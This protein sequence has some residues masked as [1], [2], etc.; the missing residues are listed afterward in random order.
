MR[1][2]QSS[3]TIDAQIRAVA[4]RQLGVITVEQAQ[5]CGV[6]RRALSRRR[7]SG[8]LVP[9]FREV[10]VLA[11][12]AVTQSQRAL[13][14]SLV[15]PGSVIA[16]TS[17]A[18]LHG[19]PVPGGASTTDDVVL[20]VDAQRVVRIPGVTVVRHG[21]MLPNRPWMTVRLATPAATLLLLPR[22]VDDTVVERCLD[23]SLANRLVSVA[24]IRRLLDQT[25]SRAVHKRRLLIGLLDARAYGVRHR[26]AG[27]QRIARW[28]ARAELTGWTPNL[29]VSVGGRQRVEVDFGWSDI[30][31]ALEVSPFF[32]HGSR[33]KQERDAQRRRLLVAAN[34]RVIEAVDGDI[35]D[36]HAFH[37]TITV[38]RSLGAT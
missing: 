9:V 27:E 35:A 14:A 34:W 2:P 38:L 33:V 18:L 19:L 23:H 11:P 16:A 1:H 30:R 3:F 36:R 28:L 21:S 20:S 17:A 37:R 15:V 26:S 25:P 32:T 22:F 6:D 8:A 12:F 29:R 24:G 13:A 10:M 5:R 31:V 4:A 7:N